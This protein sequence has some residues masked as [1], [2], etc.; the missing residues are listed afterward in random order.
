MQQEKMSSLLA[1]NNQ[2]YS[3]SICQEGTDVL[4]QEFYTIL[5]SMCKVNNI[6]NENNNNMENMQHIH[7]KPKLGSEDSYK[8]IHNLLRMDEDYFLFNENAK[9]EDRDALFFERVLDNI[10]LNI[11]NFTKTQWNELLKGVDYN[12]TNG[13]SSGWGDAWAKLCFMYNKEEFADI[14][15]FLENFSES[16]CFKNEI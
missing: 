7:S 12:Y 6:N 3:R 8:F 16:D 14:D 9:E 11:N 2:L 4:F 5:D 10:V 15:E 13:E 1:I